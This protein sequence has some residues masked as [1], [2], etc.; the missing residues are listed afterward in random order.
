MNDSLRCKKDLVLFELT[1]M[2]QSFFMLLPFGPGIS[3]IDKEA[4]KVLARPEN[5]I[6][7]FDIPGGEQHVVGAFG[8]L[9]NGNFSPGHAQH[10]VDHIDGNEIRFR[11]RGGRL[12]HELSLSAAELAKERVFGMREAHAPMIF[13][14]PRPGNKDGAG[15]ELRPGPGFWSDVH[16]GS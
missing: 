6:D 9:G 10:R 11:M 3:K 1:D 16:K 8:I 12:R 7:A 15:L 5:V 2:G 4:V 14:F 13:F